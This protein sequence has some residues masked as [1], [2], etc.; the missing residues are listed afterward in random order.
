MREIF[1]ETIRERI[2][3]EKLDNGLDVF[4][5]PRKSYNH[6][7]A[8]FATNYGSIDNSFIDP[9]SGKKVSVPDGIAHFLEHKLF[10]GEKE[11]IFDKFANLGASANA[12]TNFTTTA[13]LFSSTINFE[14]SLLNLIDFVQSPY[15]TEEN[16]EK[17]KG[18]IAQEIKM[19]EDD[20]HYQLFFSLLQGLYHNHPVKIDIAGSIDSIKKITREDLYLCYNTFYHPSNMVLFMVGDFDRNRV[21]SLVRNNQQKKD[22]PSQDD[23]KRIF[24]DEP[25]AVNEKRIIK[26]M[27]TSRP[28]FNL[29]F[30]EGRLTESGREMIKQTIA[31]NM[32]LELLVGKGTELYQSLY[33]DGLVDD[34]FHFNYTREKGYGYISM[35]GETKDPQELS[36]RLF[37]GIKEAGDRISNDNFM[38]IYKKITG[39]FL[40]EFNSLELIAGEFLNYH[41]KGLDLFVGLDVMQ[42]IDL[43]YILKRYRDLLREKSATKSIIIN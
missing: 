22:Y 10:E 8:V 28:L 1:N 35:G 6:Q 40:E 11:S 3:R 4:M 29:G 13:Y 37:R 25:E 43:N 39:N 14:E 21:L 20:P 30:K 27:D 18:I 7:Y 34:N 19:Y 36:P 32:L 33:E 17:E 2:Y 38:R 5:M 9:R 12:Y 26:K 41:F 16:V 31:T 24:P 15:F 42:E 23:I